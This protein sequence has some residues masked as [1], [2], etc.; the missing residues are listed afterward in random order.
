MK[1]LKLV[2]AMLFAVGA[3]IC[4][5]TLPNSVAGSQA[6]TNAPTTQL[7]QLVDDLHNGFGNKGTPVDECAGEPVPLQSFEDN[8]FIF[9]EL[10]SVADGLGPTYNDSS[11]GASHNHPIVDG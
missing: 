6:P 4:L 11:C 9:E 5:A 8:K 1:S 7:S 2:V 10:E 3:P